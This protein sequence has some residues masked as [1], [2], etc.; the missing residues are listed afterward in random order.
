MSF[1]YIYD[2]SK[3]VTITIEYTNTA[4]ETHEYTLETIDANY[5]I[6]SGTLNLDLSS[7]NYGYGDYV[8]KMFSENQI[9]CLD[10]E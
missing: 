1:P 9:F 7:P 2:N 10:M 8:L 6:G 5:A 4:G 3:T